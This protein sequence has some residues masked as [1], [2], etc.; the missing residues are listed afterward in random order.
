MAKGRTYGSA[1]GR[2]QRASATEGG[3]RKPAQAAARPKRSTSSPRSPGRRASDS[4]AVDALLKLLESPLVA[5]LLAV[6]ATAALAAIAESRHSRRTGADAKSSKT[7]KAAAKAAAAASGRGF[8][9]I[10]KS[11]SVEGPRGRTQSVFAPSDMR[12]TRRPAPQS[13][14]SLRAVR[15]HTSRA[16][17]SRRRQPRARTVSGSR[18]IV[19]SAKM[20]PNGSNAG[21]RAPSAEDL[22]PVERASAAAWPDRS[23]RLGVIP[24]SRRM[25]RRATFFHAARAQPAKRATRKS[26]TCERLKHRNRLATRSCRGLVARPAALSG[27][28]ASARR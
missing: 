15:S 12:S 25:Q 7:A 10:R 3:T 24:T 23:G 1:R 2:P 13:M 20:M 16:R 19:R 8:H 6:G 14:P 17:A 27:A 4:N 26:R 11:E 5:D 9:R 18:P 21:V 22:H 28:L